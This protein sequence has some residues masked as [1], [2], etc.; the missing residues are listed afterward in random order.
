MEAEG[1]RN[2]ARAEVEELK[3]KLEEASQSL[4]RV[5]GEKDQ[6]STKVKELME[7]IESREDR[8]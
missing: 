7:E 4:K 1:E 3:A 2:D 6:A 5:E 8:N